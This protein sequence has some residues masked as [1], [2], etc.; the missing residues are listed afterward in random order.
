MERTVLTW[1]QAG[2]IIAMQSSC[3]SWPS[4]ITAVEIKHYIAM[5]HEIL[6]NDSN[7]VNLDYNELLKD[8][9]HRIIAEALYRV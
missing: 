9:A 1:Q 8:S 2:C 3:W 6:F 4:R 7:R 5:K